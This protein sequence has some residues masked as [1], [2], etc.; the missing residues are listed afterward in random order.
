MTPEQFIPLVAADAVAAMKDTSVPASFTIA[1]AAL[2][3]GWGART[4]GAANNL[5]GIKADPS[6]TGPKVQAVTTEYINGRPIHVLAWFRSYPNFGASVR[7]HTAFLCT[8]ERY[9][10]CFASRDG[11]AFAKAVAAAGYATDPNYATKII[12]T[13]QTHN[14]KQFDNGAS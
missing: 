10:G 13:M 1:Q 14:L 7:D 8:N 5:F 4:I 11:E 6:W 3:S 2:E 9:A 12:D